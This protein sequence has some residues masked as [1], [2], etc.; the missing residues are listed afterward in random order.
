MVGGAG[1]AGPGRCIGIID[2]LFY[3]GQSLPDYVRSCPPRRITG[4]EVVSAVVERLNTV[5]SEL[6]RN[7]RLLAALAMKDV[8][9]SLRP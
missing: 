2:S 6:E 4:E 9:P 3:F 5:P 1:S 7:F 8:Y